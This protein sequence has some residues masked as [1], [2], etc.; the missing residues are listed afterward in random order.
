LWRA[1][2]VMARAR[3]FAKGAITMS[4]SETNTSLADAFDWGELIDAYTDGDALRDGLLIDV[5]GLQI[6]VGGMLVNRVTQ[7]VWQQECHAHKDRLLDRL[8]NHWLPTAR[9]DQDW[10]ILADS[11]LWLIPNETGGYTLLYPSDY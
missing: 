7:A 2:L 4:L 5:S 1:R 9:T 10:L 6:K 11:K 8:V 3:F